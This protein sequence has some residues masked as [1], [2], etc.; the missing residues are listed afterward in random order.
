M[1]YYLFE[2][3]ETRGLILQKFEN[4]YLQTKDDLSWE[5]LEESQNLDNLVARLEKKNTSLT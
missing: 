1:L 5:T 3:F 2:F 4:F